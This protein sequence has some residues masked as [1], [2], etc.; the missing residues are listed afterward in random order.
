MKARMKGRWGNAESGVRGKVIRAVLLR[1]R[2]CS[3]AVLK[4]A[5]T[6]ALLSLLVIP[7]LVPAQAGTTPALSTQDS[8]R[9]SARVDAVLADPAKTQPALLAGRERA[10]VCAYCHGKDGNSVKRIVPSLAAQHPGYL[11]DQLIAYASGSR[12]DFIMQGMMR[13]LSADDVV[14]IAAFYSSQVLKP[15]RPGGKGNVDNGKRLYLARCQAC[16]GAQGDGRQRYPRV[17]GQSSEYLTR[18]LR[19]YKD[20]KGKRNNPTM[21][22]LAAA[23][24]DAEIADL[25]SWLETAH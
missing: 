17:A 21:S 15:V 25:S 24:S 12:E 20:P 16:H 22:A 3:P 18:A 19:H 7:A 6:A 4:G 2:R 9:L 5:V 23:L 14:N 10:I 11:V 8:A 13:D 1:R